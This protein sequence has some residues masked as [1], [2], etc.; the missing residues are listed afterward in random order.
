M[1]RR[2]TGSPP[3]GPVPTTIASGCPQLPGDA[4]KRTAPTVAAPSDPVAEDR[5][6]W[7]EMGLPRAAAM[8]TFMSLLRCHQEVAA[9]ARK[10]L[11]PMDLSITDHAALTH[12]F[13]SPEGSHSLTRIAER[14]LVSQARCSYLMDGLERKGLVRRKAHPTDGR[15]TLAV[16]TKAGARRLHEASLAMAQANFGFEGID[17]DALDEL[18]TSLA[19]IRASTNGGSSP[20]GP[21]TAA[22]AEGK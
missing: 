20:D 6:R 12:L 14:L 21:A 22:I 19:R 16:L 7:A 5:A 13:L 15:A 8:A 2:Q 11:E 1:A 10:A 18:L 9:R 4:R 3:S 17:D